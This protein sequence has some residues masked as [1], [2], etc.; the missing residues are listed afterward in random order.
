MKRWEILWLAFEKFAIFFSFAVTFTVV[1]ILLLLAFALLHQRETLLPLKDGIVCDTV[2]GLNTLL[3]DFESAVITRT[4][5]I[6]QT[7]PVEFDLP[8][9]QNITVRMTDGVDLQRPTTMVLPGGGG[10]INGTVYLELPSGLRLPIQLNTMVPVR[11]QLPV[12]M[13]VPVAIPL[14]ETDLGG[15]IQQLRDLLAPLQLEKL[16]ETLKCPGR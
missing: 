5:S 3:D 11:Q 15:V 1:M 12:Q 14:S 10:R 2:T 13:D 16:E 9:D 7:I 8:L 6:S 4:I